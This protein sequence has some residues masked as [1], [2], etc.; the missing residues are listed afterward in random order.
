MLCWRLGRRG[1]GYRDIVTIYIKRY[2]GVNEESQSVIYC[3][4]E[5]ESVF[6]YIVKGK[7]IVEGKVVK[8]CSIKP[9]GKSG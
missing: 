6:D 9:M 3:F 4:G 5:L 1:N 7:W 2:G 8:E